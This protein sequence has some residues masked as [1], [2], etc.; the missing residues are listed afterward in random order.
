MHAIIH[1]CTVLEPQAEGLEELFV[2]L[3]LVLHHRCKLVLDF[4]FERTC[5]ELEVTVMLKQL[6]GNIQRQIS[7]ES[8]RPRTKLK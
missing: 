3:A 6:T 5:D 1:V 4:L 8:T 7:A 2:V